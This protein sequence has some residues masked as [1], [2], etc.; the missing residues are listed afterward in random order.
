MTENLKQYSRV[1][2]GYLIN[3][4]ESAPSETEKAFPKVTAESLLKQLIHPAEQNRLEVVLG[5]FDSTTQFLQ[6]LRAVLLGLEAFEEEEALKK[7]VPI[8]AQVEADAMNKVPNEGLALSELTG[9]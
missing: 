5:T 9:M 8:M 3:A 2:D 7:F 6:A 1:E 4:G